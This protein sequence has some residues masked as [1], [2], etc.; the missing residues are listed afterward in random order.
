MSWGDDDDSIPSDDTLRSPIV[1]VHNHS[2]PRGGTVST[3][4]RVYPLTFI[5]HKSTYDRLL[6]DVD[7]S[8]LLTP[9]GEPLNL[10]SHAFKDALASKRV[11]CIHACHQRP[12]YRYFVTSEH[13][14]KT[15][16]SDRD[17]GYAARWK[18][19]HIYDDEAEFPELRTKLRVLD[20]SLAPRHVVAP[21][22][23]SVLP[24]RGSPRHHETSSEGSGSGV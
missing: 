16:A 24:S 1:V 22:S 8:P 12:G 19:Y 20:P 18:H 5:H 6:F 4:F 15:F 11:R 23:Q 3:S 13:Q 2:S 14:R 7:G 10:Y 21:R 9:Q 17:N